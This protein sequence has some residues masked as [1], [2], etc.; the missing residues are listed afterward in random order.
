MSHS[1][2][3]ISANAIGV[4][5]PVYNRPRLILDALDSVSRQT[6]KPSKIVVV[7]GAGCWVHGGSYATFPEARAK[8]QELLGDALIVER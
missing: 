8:R 7:E 5:I 1:D 6:I 3:S 2:T 4:V